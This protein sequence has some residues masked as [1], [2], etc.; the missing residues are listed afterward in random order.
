VSF[1][2]DLPEDAEII[3]EFGNS[4]LIDDGETTRSIAR[5]PAYELAYVY[6]HA[7][8]VFGDTETPPT[9]F[10]VPPEVRVEPTRSDRVFTLQID[11]GRPVQNPPSE[12][13][14]VLKGVLEIVRN[15]TAD[16]LAHL[17]DDLCERQVDKELIT[18]VQRQ[19]AP[20]PPASVQITD[21][22]WVIED[23]F[24]LTWLGTVYL[25]TRNFDDPTYRIG[26]GIS[27]TD[28]DVEFIGLTPR[29]DPDPFE[30]PGDDESLDE[31]EMLFLWKAYWLATYRERHDDDL[32][33][34]LIER[35]VQET[36]A[37]AQN[38]R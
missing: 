9:I 22:G 15:G 14:R 24:L 10:D 3:G 32:F 5:T 13:D 27:R 6:G 35:H 4:Y 29:G 7:D 30:L 1:G 12:T 34:D 17:Y 26:G 36:R 37:Q 19:Y 33:W 11:D 18:R 20:V 16:T 31:R 21:D 38:H 28:E 23:M 2:E 25:V 8:L